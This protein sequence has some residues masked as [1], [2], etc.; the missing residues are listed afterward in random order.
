MS[1]NTTGAH[2]N[3]VCPTGHTVV[4]SSHWPLSLTGMLGLLLMPLRRY[5]DRS[6]DVGMLAVMELWP[7]RSFTISNL[8]Q[9]SIFLRCR[10]VRKPAENYH[11][12][13]EVCN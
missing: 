13:Y 4:R 7:V 11:S 1:V 5:W 9:V 10:T 2:D 3:T 6:N 8:K 12:Q